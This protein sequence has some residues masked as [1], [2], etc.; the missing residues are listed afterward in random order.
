MIYSSEWSFLQF[1][2]KVEKWNRWA[3]RT[4]KDP[5][6]AGKIQVSRGWLRE[7]VKMR[8][9]CWWKSDENEDIQDWQKWVGKLERSAKD[10]SKERRQLVLDSRTKRVLGRTRWWMFMCFISTMT[11]VLVLLVNASIICIHD[12]CQFTWFKISNR[13]EALQ[14][15]RLSS[16]AIE[17][18]LCR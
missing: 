15:R 8:K 11:S 10:E 18:P 1:S 12:R 13:L 2:D 16:S 7:C 17:F 5:V 3:R 6:E 9:V 4:H 14:M